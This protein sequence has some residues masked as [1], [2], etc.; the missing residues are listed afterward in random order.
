MLAP[1]HSLIS[2]SR[3]RWAIQKY[4]SS[5]QQKEWA[6]SGAGMS[7]K[8]PDFIE[9]AVRKRLLP[10][11]S[12]VPEFEYSEVID[13]FVYGTYQNSPGEAI[14]FSDRGIRIIQGETE[15]LILYED[16]NAFMQP[17]P[18]AEFSAAA[19]IALPFRSIYIKLNTNE[20]LPLPVLNETTSFQPGA[21]ETATLDLYAVCEFL[22]ELVDTFKKRALDYPALLAYS[23]VGF[24]VAHLALILLSHSVP[25][26]HGFA[27]AAMD[28]T[29]TLMLIS[30]FGWIYL[31]ILRQS[32]R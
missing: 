23:T 30:M 13:E 19:K 25:A 31:A 18:E 27:Y 7:S 1:L 32:A 26:S 4:N 2:R 8:A 6:V 11:A 14:L 28:W 21:P 29:F 16:M 3:H 12:F 17:E 24:L 9:L 20:L 15:R 10:L 5:R 22:V